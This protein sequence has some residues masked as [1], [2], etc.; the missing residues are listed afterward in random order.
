MKQ[1]VVIVHGADSFTSYEAFLK[2]LAEKAK[3]VELKDFDRKGWKKSFGKSLGDLYEVV[4]PSMPNGENA[5]YKEW[6]I[7][8]DGFFEKFDKDAVFIGH[9]MG[10]IFLAKYFIEKGS[11][12]KKLILIAPPFCDSDLEKLDDFNFDVNHSFDVLNTPTTYIL[13]STDDPVVPYAHSLLYKERLNRAE[14]ITF[15]DRM[16]F[17]QEVFPELVDLVQQR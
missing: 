5:K 6:K 3:M 12:P 14:L 7:W 8:F 17:N 13:H 4:L 10:A 9:S 2:A 11:A 16:H 15:N 1:Q